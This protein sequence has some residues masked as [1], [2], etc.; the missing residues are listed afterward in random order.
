MSQKPEHQ[1]DSQRR[2][3][4]KQHTVDADLKDRHHDEE[5]RGSRQHGAQRVEAP[6]SVGRHRI[7]EPPAQPDDESDYRRLYQEGDS[8]TDR[9]RDQP[10]DERARR[11][12]D[13]GH[14]A[15]HAEGTR[16]RLQVVEEHGRQ[17]VDRR[18]HQRAADALECR[19]ADDQYAE[20]R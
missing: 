9:G 16:T 3:D 17:D 14:A 15:D 20:H 12:A 5:H 13:A 4:H 10:T 11:G 7:A 8:P 19:V 2:E 6:A 1:S 18:D